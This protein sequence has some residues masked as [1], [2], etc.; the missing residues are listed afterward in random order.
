MLQAFHQLRDGH[1]GDEL[2]G[3]D[4]DEAR[5]QHDD[6]VAQQV[7]Q[8]VVA[9]VA[10]HRHLALAVVQRVQLP[11]PVELVLAAVDPVVQQVEHHQVDG[12]GQH[13]HVGHAGPH[14]VEVEGAPARRAQ[15]AHGVVEKRLQHEEDG[16]AEQAEPV[17]Q[18]VEHVDA[19]G[20]AVDHR[21]HR[22]PALQ[23]A[24]HRDQHHDL[25][26]AD[27]QPAGGVEGILGPAAQAHGE[28]QRL[29]R[30]LENQPCSAAKTSVKPLDHG[31]PQ[32]GCD[33]GAVVGVLAQGFESRSPW[34]SGRR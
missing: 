4:A 5:R 7:V 28:D 8:Q 14:L 29:D 16:Q 21:L 10:P 19:D 25:D 24:D 13:R 34:P 18:R 17:D 9:V 23:R 32:V 3:R 33:P 6:G 31:R 1:D 12:K 30:R 27:Q 20:L 11:P 26:G 2:P 15:A 22:A